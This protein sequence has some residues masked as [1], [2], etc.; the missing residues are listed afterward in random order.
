MIPTNKKKTTK[1]MRFSVFSSISCFLVLIILHSLG[2]FK[3]V[4]RQA[5]KP[6]PPKSLPSSSSKTSPTIYVPESLPLIAD[7]VET[8][9]MVAGEMDE[10]AKSLVSSKEPEFVQV[11]VPEAPPLVS[12]Y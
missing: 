1:A 9:V 11:E 3:T 10:M 2:S 12:F 5:Q 6:P 8:Q 4:L 7:N